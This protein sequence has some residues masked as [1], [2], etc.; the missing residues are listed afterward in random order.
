MQLIRTSHDGST[1]IEY[2]ARAVMKHRAEETDTA[3]N[4]ALLELYSSRR[5]LPSVSAALKDSGTLPRSPVGCVK[6]VCP[7]CLLTFDENDHCRMLST[8]CM[9][10]AGKSCISK[11]GEYSLR[12]CM[13]KSVID[14]YVRDFNFIP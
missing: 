11:A 6:N 12:C 8:K 10:A 7:M 3:A 13:C 5:L 4:V 1:D 2:T 14:D 9:H